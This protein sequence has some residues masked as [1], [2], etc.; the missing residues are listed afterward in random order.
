MKL[1]WYGFDFGETLMNPYTLHQSTLIRRI[2]AEIGRPNEAEERVQKWYRLRN[3]AGSS[4]DRAELR[5]RF[6]KQYARDRIYSEVLGGDS[7]AIRLY[8]IGEAEGFTPAKGVEKALLGLRE[9]GSVASIVSETSQQAAALAIAR[10]LHVH[11]LG[12]LINEIITPAGRFSVRGEMVGPEFV[13]KTKKDGTIFDELKSYL[14]R[15]GV[16]AGK[17]A[18]VGD[19][20][21][22]DIANAKKRGFVVV[23]YI[24]IVNRGASEAD[25]VIDDWAKLPAEPNIGPPPFSPEKVR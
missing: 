6:L 12:G 23:Q 16:D 1:E 24:G 15:L 7:Q 20:P 2:Y 25:Y 11:G 17:A 5:V 3:A 19:D 8:E 22:L 10:F 9:R 13:G 18:V 4:T 14:N 21:Q